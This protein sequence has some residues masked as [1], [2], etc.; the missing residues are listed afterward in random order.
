MYMYI[1]IYISMHEPQ[2]G[3]TVFQIL[4]PGGERVSWVSPS[5]GDAERVNLAGPEGNGE[6]SDGRFYMSIPYAPC[7]EYESQRLAHKLIYPNFVKYSIQMEHLGII[8]G[9]CLGV[10]LDEKDAI[11]GIDV[12]EKRWHL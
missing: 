9:T 10:K 6:T 7:M 3:G 11:D 12:D 1:Y 4:S 2:R 5:P 8:Y